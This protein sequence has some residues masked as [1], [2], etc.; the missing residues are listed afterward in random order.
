MKSFIKFL[1]RHNLQG[2]ARMQFP[3]NINYD[4]EVITLGLLEGESPTVVQWNGLSLG[5]LP[6]RSQCPLG[7]ISMPSCSY[8]EKS[9]KSNYMTCLN[10]LDTLF[11]L[12]PSHP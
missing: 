12:I 6:S 8:V 5:K 4:P 7:Q 1:H 9:A 10:C 2:F 3:T 11:L